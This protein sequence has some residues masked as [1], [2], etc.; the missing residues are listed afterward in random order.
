MKGANFNYLNFTLQK[1][2]AISLLQFRTGFADTLEYI[3]L[4]EALR[5]KNVSIREVSES[6]SVNNLSLVNDSDHFIFISDGDILEGAKQNR[7]LNTSVFIAPHTV[8]EI[9]VSCVEAGRWRYRKKDFSHSKSYMPRDIRIEKMK[10]VEENLFESGK[11]YADQSEIWNEVRCYEDTLDS[12][13]ASSDLNELFSKKEKELLELTG[14][15]TY[16]EGSNGMAVFSGNRLISVEIF[17][18]A[19]IFREYFPK[20]LKSTA[21]ELLKADINSQDISYEESVRAAEEFMNETEK[22]NPKIHKGVG[23]GTEKRFSSDMLTGFELNYDKKPVHF[24]AL[25]ENIRSQKIL[26][27]RHGRAILNF[28][29][30]K[31]YDLLTVYR[32]DR[33]YIQWLCFDADID[34][35]LKRE[36]YDEV[37]KFGRN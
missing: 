2:G 3:P 27:D 20:L 19:E 22:I 15:L 32:M 23:A 18:R 30:F 31:G 24:V 4:S 37:L 26:R 29:K 16:T 8:T 9:P 1:Q 11:A 6:G 10:K 7:V 21:I 12:R 33:H 36:I 25:N 14:N 5:N 34:T 13:S 28:G 17:N 35:D